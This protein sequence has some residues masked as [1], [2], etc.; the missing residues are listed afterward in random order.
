MPIEAGNGSEFMKQDIETLQQNKIR[1]T[2]EA[3]E[4]LETTTISETAL[5]KVIASGA[6]FVSKEIVEKAIASEEKIPAHIQG[7]RVAGFRP[8]AK[9][10]EPN[11][12]IIDKSDVSGKSN[13]T[14]KLDDF[15]AHFRNRFER[16]SGILRSRV[17]ANPVI[18]TNKL[19]DSAGSKV[20]FI[21]MVTQNA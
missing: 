18:K 10:H 3:Y 20:R 2:L 17:S 12:K 1:L 9:E 21:A 11:Y 13:C 15:V 8:V 5:K 14:G 4:F 19:K 16:I 6:L 7:S